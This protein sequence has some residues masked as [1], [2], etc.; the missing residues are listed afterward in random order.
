MHQEQQY[1]T[2]TITCAG[3]RSPT[4]E[5]NISRSS[6]FSIDEEE[7]LFLKL[8]A[9]L[10][11]PPN[12]K[13]ERN[14]K[15]V[16][17]TTWNHYISKLFGEYSF[18]VS[19]EICSWWWFSGDHCHQSPQNR[20]H[21]IWYT[22]CHRYCYCH[23]HCNH[24]YNCYCFIQDV[25]VVV[26]F[27]ITLSRSSYIHRWFFSFYVFFI[28]IIFSLRYESSTLILYKELS[29]TIFQSCQSVNE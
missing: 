21:R 14:T 29:S 6:K 3:G 25:P 12:P 9:W 10:P 5:N 28:F 18:C 2:V 8:G 19:C 24:H 15:V 11:D 27:G 26:G 13:V 7:I 17:S 4:T 23:R 16:K 1:I 22:Y 20:C